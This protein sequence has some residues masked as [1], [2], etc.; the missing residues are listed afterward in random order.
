MCV[1]TT[2]MD[3]L[4]LCPHIPWNLFSLDAI[5]SVCVCDGDD[6][7]LAQS[8]GAPRAEPRARG[9]RGTGEG[10]TVARGADEACWREKSAAADG[11][12]TE[13]GRREA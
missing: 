4:V 13:Q 11:E 9:E 6:G 3:R 7:I 8:F 5:L 12:E 1:L 10:S 2:T